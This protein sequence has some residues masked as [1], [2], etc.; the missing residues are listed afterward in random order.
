LQL[1]CGSYNIISIRSRPAVIK[2]FIA[3]SIF[4]PVAM[5]NFAPVHAINEPINEP[6]TVLAAVATYAL[7]S[8][9]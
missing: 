1:I 2:T 9:L 3:S 5:S 8:M 4:F 6:S 7:K